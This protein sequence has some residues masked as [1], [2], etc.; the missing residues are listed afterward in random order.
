[1]KFA[2][3]GPVADI[4]VE[5]ANGRF[6]KIAE[7]VVAQSFQ[8]AI[9]GKIVDLLA[10]LRRTLD[11]SERAAHRVDFGALV[12][13]AILHLH[14]DGSAQRVEAERGIVGHDGD[15]PDRSGRDQVPVDGV[16]ERFVDAH[17]VLVNRQSLRRTGDRRCDKTSK[18]HVRHKWIAGRVADDEARHVL[19]QGV[20]DVQ[21]VGARDLRGADR[22][23]ACRHLVDIDSHAGDRRRR[24]RV[25]KNPAHVPGGGGGP[26]RISAAGAA[27][28]LGGWRRRNYLD[29]GQY[30]VASGRV[31]GLSA[32]TS[33][34]ETQRYCPDKQES[35]AHC[36]SSPFP[37]RH[38]GPLPVGC[39]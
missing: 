34:N 31:L 16:A 33:G 23:D 37:I 27:D 17:P 15:R 18:L 20:R 9:D 35:S 11:A 3:V 2:A 29:G 22:V 10:V 5:P 36:V 25:D 19:L 28:R 6:R 13:E 30:L 12:V 7:A 32:V 4:A 8:R 21:R 39:G 24:G 1:M 14:V 26:R 38:I